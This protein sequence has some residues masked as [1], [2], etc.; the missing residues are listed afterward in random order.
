M[1]RSRVK[2]EC[3]DRGRDQPE[4]QH[5]H[6]QAGE[7][8]R[9]A[10]E[11]LPAQNGRGRD[12]DR[13]RNATEPMARAQRPEVHRAGA[14]QRRDRGRQHHHVVAVDDPGHEAEHQHVDGQPEAPH[15]VG[16]AR[17][18][19]PAR[20]PAN[21]QPAD[22][23]DRRERQEP[24]NLAA[25]LGVEHAQQPGRAAE[26]AA[27]AAATRAAAPPPPAEDAAEAVIAEEQLERGV[28]GAA[29]DVRP[30]GRGDELDR[31]HPPAAADDHGHERADQVEQALAQVAR[32][33]RWRR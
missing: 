25:E 27:A 15:E 24:G 23:A 21:R 12:G 31:D 7:E 19:R 30:V 8:A 28:V 2:W 18:V 1:L 20:A 3:H 5:G 6:G 33:P 17:Q 13:E 32:A 26:A 22:Q 29:A 9:R 16:G 11:Q 14:D 10:L 4:D